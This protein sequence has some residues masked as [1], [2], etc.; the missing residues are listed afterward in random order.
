MLTSLSRRL[1]RNAVR[2]SN[3]HQSTSVIEDPLGLD[4]DYDKESVVRYFSCFFSLWKTLIFFAR[5]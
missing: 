4:K 2:R 5:R 3:F 1:A